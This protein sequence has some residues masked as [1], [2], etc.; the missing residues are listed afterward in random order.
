MNEAKNIR[1]L[2]HSRSESGRPTLAILEAALFPGPE[3]AE[4]Q[5]FQCQRQRSFHAVYL[6]P[7]FRLAFRK[8]DPKR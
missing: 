1:N 4:I 2:R 6:Q 5:S 8:A 7:L 3:S